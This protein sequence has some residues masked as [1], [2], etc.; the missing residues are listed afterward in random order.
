MLPVFGGGSPP[1]FCRPYHLDADPAGVWQ[2]E[3]LDRNSHD[4][5][6]EL[7]EHEHAN[8]IGQCFNE[9]PASSL[10]KRSHRLADGKVVNCISQVVGGPAWPEVVGHLDGDEKSLRL[11]SFFVRH[12]NV[13]PDLQ[14]LDGDMVRHRRELLLWP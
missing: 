11:R 12:A 5:W 7:I 4:A 10:A 9:F 3:F 2:D 6:A 13:K 8:V 14:V 1:V